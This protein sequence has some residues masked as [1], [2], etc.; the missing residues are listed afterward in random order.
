M[1]SGEFLARFWLSPQLVTYI[2]LQGFR[3]AMYCLS[4]SIL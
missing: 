2:A 4:P 1:N 3:L